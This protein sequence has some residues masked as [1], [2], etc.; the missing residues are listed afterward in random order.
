MRQPVA[1]VLALAAAALAEPQLPRAAHARL[2]QIVEQ[3]EW[4]AEIIG[5][6]LEGD[7]NAVSSY[8]TD[9]GQAAKEA[10]AA[11]WL[12]WAG[13]ISLVGP[14]EPVCVAIHPVVLRRIA[15]NLL[16]NAAR[17]AGPAGAMRI[18]ISSRTGWV[19]LMVEDNGPGF[20]QI[21]QG[22]GLGLSA[23]TRC[24]VKHGGRLEC[25][26]SPLGGACVALWLPAAVGPAEGN[27]PAAGRSRSRWR[28][29]SALRH[30]WPLSS[31]TGAADQDHQQRQG[32]DL[33]GARPPVRR[34]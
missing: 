3:A 14:A 15:A 10:A 29:W 6:G 22:L 7:R 5:Q 2:R 28:K 31:A 26:R 12:T 25:T 13:E 24:V 9:V 20:G 16:D 30:H 32:S 17:A 34:P 21:Q 23:A 33:A 1:G 8:R 18:T 11:Q 27:L 19:L 4:L